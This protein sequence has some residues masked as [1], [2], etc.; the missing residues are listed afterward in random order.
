MFGLNQVETANAFGVHP[1]TVSEWERGTIGPPDSIAFAMHTFAEAYRDAAHVDPATLPNVEPGSIRKTYALQKC[2]T[3]RTRILKRME[4]I[5]DEP[6]R[7]RGRP[8]K[9][10]KR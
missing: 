7:G 5:P 2:V 8:R 9:A 1:M 4:E 6:P 10:A 3:V